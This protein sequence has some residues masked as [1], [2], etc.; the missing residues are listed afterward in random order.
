MKV[1]TEKLP[2][3][4]IALR[5]EI[6]DER[7]ERAKD[8]AYRRLASKVK[9]PGFRPGK[10]PRPILERHLGEGALLQEAL[11]RLMPEV[12]REAL[13]QEGIEPVD[14]AEYELEAES[15]LV[16]K[17]TVPVRPSVELGDYASLR[18]DREPVA[19]EAERVQEQLEMLRHRY[20]TYEPV[21]RPVA[22]GDILRADVHGTVDGATL[23]REE[24]AQFRILEGQVVSLPGF[25]EAL[26]G[27]AKGAA[28]EFEVT[29]PEDAPDQRWR[30]KPARYRV[31]VK[32]IKE[33][34]LPELDDEFARQVGEGFAS[35]DALRSRI[36]DDLRRALEDAEEH[37]YHD[38]ILDTLLERSTL[39]YP[40]VLVEREVDHLLEDE[41]GAARSG[42]RDGREALE[43]YLQ[44]LGKSEEE[45]R[46]ELRPIAERRIHRSLVLSQV[47]EA[48]HIE[49]TGAE[50]EAEIERLASGAGSQTEE[51]RRLFSSEEAR[52]S[53]RRS[54]LTRKTLDRLVAIA[55]GAG[56]MPHEAKAGATQ[57]E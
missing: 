11:D 39:E 15:P 56:A 38:R 37:R 42:G 19:V 5:I 33:E 53:L 18:L 46:Q 55:S 20:A 1:S 48:E 12:Y 29:V 52:A 45:V 49:V 31:H 9:I 3:S 8:S 41:T 35:L 34:R 47:T 4:Q 26:V 57:D 10:V 7:V 6:D 24:D 25:A 23:V 36:E 27:H 28:F 16:A 17:F 22:W 30:G 54:L 50:V 13:D 21:E 14:R 43:R 44:R 51:L 40:P 2:Q 32:E